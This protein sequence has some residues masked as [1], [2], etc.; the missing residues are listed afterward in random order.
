MKEQL[1]DRLNCILNSK[2][3][4]KNYIEEV[5]SIRQQLVDY[6][7]VEE[8][9]DISNSIRNK[10][11]LEAN[12]SLKNHNNFGSVFM[13]TGTGKS[14]VGVNLAVEK[15]SEN[16]YS[17]GLLVVPTEKLRDEHWKDE[18][19]KW[20]ASSIYEKNII[21]TCYASL[22]NFKDYV[23]D[24]VILDEGH[25]IT[26]LKEIFFKQNV[27]KSCVL[28][29]ATKP[30]DQ[31]K[32]DILKRYNLFTRYE[33]FIDDSVKL[34]LIAPFEI[35]VIYTTLDNINKYIK[36]GNTSN[37]F[38]QTEKQRYNFLSKNNSSLGYINRMRFIYNLRSKTQAAKYILDNI[39][40]KELR[41]IIFCGSKL[42]SIELCSRRF[43]SKPTLDKKHRNNLIKKAEYQYLIDNYEEDRAYNDFKE[44]KINRMSCINAVNEGHNLPLIDCGF[45]VQI[46][47]NELHLFQRL[48]RIVRYRPGYIAKMIILC[49]KDSADYNWIQ[50]AIKNLNGVNINYYEFSRLQM[51]ID[52]IKF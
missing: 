37:V 36:A 50:S 45:I 43:F 52:K 48:G 42:Q 10:V 1:L 47:S 41:T 6:I 2:D 38:Y 15:V 19:S 44:N 27:I 9:W 8:E 30:K 21:R 22:D 49:V 40:P 18:F 12:T 25:N 11:Q 4:I 16:K 5:Y 24:F 39:I 23:F 33:L 17:N 34:G 46:N 26:E 29:S 32:V 35:D 13:A 28:L 3:S 20:G 14:K 51:N 7:T 31:I